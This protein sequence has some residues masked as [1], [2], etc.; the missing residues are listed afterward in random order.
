M[1]GGRPI[2]LQAY[3]RGKGNPNIQDLIKVNY[4]GNLINVN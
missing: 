3:K 2:L 1:I 4:Q